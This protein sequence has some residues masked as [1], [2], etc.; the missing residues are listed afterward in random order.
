MAGR[1]A[2]GTKA[3][4]Q[5]ASG[6]SSGRGS[7]CKHLHETWRQRRRP[8]LY[9][10]R[11]YLKYIRMKLLRSEQEDGSSQTLFKN[12]SRL[13]AFLRTP[14]CTSCCSTCS[15]AGKRRF[16]NASMPPGLLPPAWRMSA[17]TDS[18]K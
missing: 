15:K 16:S 13:R 12:V 1:S 8:E 7:I 2:M 18:N 9:E 10:L 17:A 3:A 6:S 4:C 11:K 14:T 5:V